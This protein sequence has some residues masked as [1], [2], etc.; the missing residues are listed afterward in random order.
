MDTDDG[1]DGDDDDDDDDKVTVTATA[2]ATAPLPAGPWR[3]Q[4]AKTAEEDHE[5]MRTREAIEDRPLKNGTAGPIGESG[6]RQGRPGAVLSLLLS[7]SLHH[8]IGAKAAGGKAPPPGLPAPRP[9]PPQ[10]VA[11]A[12]LAR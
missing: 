7:L 5:K 1:D 12:L 4:T 9:R 8:T 2:A 10:R 11:S 3:I 6:P